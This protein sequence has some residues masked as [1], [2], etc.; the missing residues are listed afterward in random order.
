MC[1]LKRLASASFCL[2]YFSR[3]LCHAGNRSF[4]QL[5]T[6]PMTCLS[7]LEADLPMS[8][9]YMSVCLACKK[10]LFRPLD[11][12]ITRDLIDWK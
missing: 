4:C 1:Y 9:A 8:N 2:V 5:V 7:M 6:L 12:H 11:F 3:V 10:S